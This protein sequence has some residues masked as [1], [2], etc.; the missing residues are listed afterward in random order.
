MRLFT[1]LVLL[2]G[3]AQ[4]SAYSIP[5]GY[6]RVL[7]YYL[8]SLDCQLN[9]GTSKRVATGCS[10]SIGSKQPCTLD[11]LLRYIAADP[12]SLPTESAPAT[13]YP[14]LPD[15]DDTAKKLSAKYT[16]YDPERDFSGQ[17][18]TGKALLNGNKDYSIFLNQLGR[19]AIQLAERSSSDNLRLLMANIEAVRNTRKSAML[20]TFITAN[21]DIDVESKPEPLYDGAPDDLKVDVI[22]LAKT[23][24]KNSG[25]TK[26][27]LI[28]RWE[29]NGEGGHQSNLD[30]LK[31]ALTEIGYHC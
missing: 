9:G 17:I 3:I 20:S 14:E 10:K 22:D 25:L 24:K 5:G 29:E 27:D 15:M 11:Q 4:T 31:A 18:H 2:F 12:N 7:I 13:S 21:T 19:E 8:Y 30:Q 6:E 1:L 16:N 28:K 26:D 23:W